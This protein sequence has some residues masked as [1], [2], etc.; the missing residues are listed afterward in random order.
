[1]EKIVKLI[2]ALFTCLFLVIG[3]Y[4]MFK[5]DLSSTIFPFTINNLE[6]AAEFR[7]VFGGS[8]LAFGY[9][10]LRFLTSS[11]TVT[12]SSIIIYI[13]VCINSGRIISFFYE[14][15]LSFTLYSWFIELSLLIFVWF[16]HKN[17]K[18]KID[19]YL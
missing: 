7:A 11:S 2:L 18:N 8:L 3:F 17:R 9:L 15:F 10:L 13:L 4:V 1:M 19:Y 16:A 12:V 14:G 5:A 6:T